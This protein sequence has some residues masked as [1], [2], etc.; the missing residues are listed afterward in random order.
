MMQTTQQLIA[1]ISMD[2]SVDQKVLEVF[3]NM[4]DALKIEV[5]H[6][7]EYLLN[8]EI[9]KPSSSNV[10]TNNDLPKQKYRK[11]GTMKGMII[12]ADDFDEPL[13]ELQEY[14]D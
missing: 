5:L 7:A 2:E 9:D 11:A 10:V 4:P 12:M 13:A 3:A 6:Y 1:T 8:K 14:M